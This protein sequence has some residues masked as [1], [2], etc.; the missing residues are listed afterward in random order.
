MKVKEIQE[1]AAKGIA[2][3][4]YMGA[5]GYQTYTPS[6][7][8][9]T[10]NKSKSGPIRLKTNIRNTCTFDFQA[11]VCKDY[12]ETGYCGY[13]DNCKFLHDRGDYKTGWQLEKEWEDEQ[14][15]K[16]AQ[17]LNGKAFGIG[18]DSEDDLSD[19]D[20]DSLPFACLKCRNKWTPTRM[21]V[22]TKCGH[23]FCENCLLNHFKKS[24][25][26]PYCKEQT[27]KFY[28]VSKRVVKKIR[29]EIKKAVEE[30]NNPEAIGQEDPADSRPRDV[31]LDKRKLAV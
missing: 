28:N 24:S 26:C 14:N 15:A 22:I 9:D 19:D 5:S 4:Y 25:K 3:G 31:R 1:R 13:G 30:A 6:M 10:L 12:K 2:A 21:P 7:S 29:E 16:V 18:D 17:V 23:L 11:D 20:E 27:G 8:D